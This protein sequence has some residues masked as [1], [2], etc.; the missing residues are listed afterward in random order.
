MG[1]HRI[2]EGYS[3]LNNVNILII[4]EKGDCY[5]FPTG[6]D[7]RLNRTVILAYRLKNSHGDGMNA[8]YQDRNH[9]DSVVRIDQDVIFEMSKVLTTKTIVYSE[10]E[11]ESFANV[12]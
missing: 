8:T 6:F 9:Y 11:K 3:R 10:A 12:D 1:W 2:V 5:S 4:N 7:R